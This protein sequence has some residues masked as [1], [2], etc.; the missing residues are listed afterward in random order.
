MTPRAL[1]KISSFTS[2]RRA[3]GLSQ[4]ESDVLVDLAS[5]PG[6]SSADIADRIGAN[7]ATLRRHL[8]GLRNSGYIIRKVNDGDVRLVDF[9]LSDKGQEF[10]NSLCKAIG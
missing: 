5:N 2:S 4:V 9:S 8:S 7:R 10:V 1:K 3:S 6:S